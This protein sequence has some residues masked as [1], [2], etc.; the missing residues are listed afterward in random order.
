[1]EN[2][3]INF[4]SVKLFHLLFLVL[5]TNRTLFSKSEAAQCME[6]MSYIL[7]FICIYFYIHN[8]FLLLRES[9]LVKDIDFYILLFLQL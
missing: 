3:V 9:S 2:A 8:P 7:T 5:I 1:M 4:S 6:E